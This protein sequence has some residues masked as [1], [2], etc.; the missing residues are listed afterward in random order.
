MPCRIRARGSCMW[1]GW[2][3]LQGLKDSSASSASREPILQRSKNS[4]LAMGLNFKQRR[5]VRPSPLSMEGLGSG[6]EEVE[7]AA[8][9]ACPP[10]SLRRLLRSHRLPPHQRLSLLQSLRRKHPSPHPRP[11]RH[12]RWVLVA[13]DG[14]ADPVDGLKDL[15]RRPRFLLLRQ[16]HRLRHRQPPPLPSRRRLRAHNRAEPPD[17]AEARLK[18]CI[19]AGGGFASPER[20]QSSPNKF[21]FA[22]FINRPRQCIPQQSVR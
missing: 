14:I 1:P 12:R 6:V 10:R 21:R 16:G 11:H 9:P 8:V 22:E 3:F 5:S 18:R 17:I 19:W 2:R 20:G 4:A 13:I 7:A 15:Q